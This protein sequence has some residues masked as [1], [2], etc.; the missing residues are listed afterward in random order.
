M[1]TTK[2]NNETL[3]HETN[4]TIIGDCKKLLIIAVIVL[5]FFK[6]HYYKES[7]IMLLNLLVSHFYLFILPGYALMLYY[8]DKLEFSERFVIGLGIGYGVQPLLLYL[9]NTVI[10]VNILK[11]NIFVSG[12]MII[13]GILLAKK[14]IL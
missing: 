7:I 11:Y 6:V 2:I 13:I 1:N 12:A 5:I 14:K 10:E 3:H 8:I 9:I 4:S